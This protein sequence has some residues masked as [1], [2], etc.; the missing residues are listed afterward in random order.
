MG[1]WSRATAVGI[2]T[3]LLAAGLGIAAPAAGARV[4][5]NADTGSA[6]RGVRAPYADLADADT[7]ADLWNRSPTEEV[8]VGSIVKVMT[9]YVVIQEGNLDRRITVPRGITR[10]DREYDAS[11]AGLKPGERLTARQLL[12]GML[13]SSGCDA[14][15]TLAAS[16]GP[17]LSAFTQKMN[18]TAAQLGLTRTYFTDVS[19]LPNPSAHS[20]YSDARDLVSLGRAA[21]ELP[22]FAS[23]VRLGSY[24]LPAK[25]GLHPSFRWKTTNPLIGKYAGVTGIKT[26]N[27]DAAGYCLLF[28]AT[29][30]G[31]TLIG[32]VLDDQGFKTAG[33]DAERMMHWGWSN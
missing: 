18:E 23:I 24:R 26:G 7:G 9:A 8:P 32:V 30:N 4:T 22:L 6:P 12:Y 16:Y 25:R 15:Y 11:T 19:G 21:M 33:N 3:S 27:T 31:R 2:T 29:R 20:T 13:I 1:A 14:A 28:E 5:R 17:G 10:Y